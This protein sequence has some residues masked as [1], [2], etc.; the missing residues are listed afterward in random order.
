MFW[1]C[2]DLTLSPTSP[3]LS[4]L[5][6]TSQGLSCGPLSHR[7]EKTALPWRFI[8]AQ[9]RPTHLLTSRSRWTP[10]PRFGH[11]LLPFNGRLV[12][13]GG[14]GAGTSRGNWR[15]NPDLTGLRMD[16]AVLDVGIPRVES[17][18][19]SSLPEDGRNPDS[20]LPIRLFLRG[21]GFGECDD[22]VWVDDRNLC[23]STCPASKSVL[24]QGIPNTWTGYGY[25]NSDSGL[26]MFVRNQTDPQDPGMCCCCCC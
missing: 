16:T 1:L 9:W 12:T 11:T 4:Q 8:E 21:S 13:F 14:F 17:V 23:R 7:S 24:S 6:L 15:S 20:G 18:S 3:L 19:P 5:G 2:C 25:D 22:W 10:A 26:D